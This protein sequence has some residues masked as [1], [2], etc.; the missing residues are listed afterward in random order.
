[1]CSRIDNFTGTEEQYIQYLE[2]TVLSL[3]KSCSTPSPSPATSPLNTSA[4]HLPPPDSSATGS[5]R[6][7]GSAASQSDT[8]NS[9]QELQ[10]V[11]WNPTSP[12]PKRKKTVSPYWKKVANALVNKTPRE[13]DW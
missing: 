12:K 10:I 6:R 3:R 4:A 13:E 8:S 11:Q 5:L 9:E 2:R 7:R 1:M